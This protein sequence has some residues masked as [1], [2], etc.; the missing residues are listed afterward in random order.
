MKHTNKQPAIMWSIRAI[1]LLLTVLLGASSSFAQEGKAPSTGI[2][3]GNYIYNFGL[4]AGYRSSSLTDA[5]G[6]I[7]TFATARYNEAYNL[8]SGLI[9]NSFNLYGEKK[10]GEGFFDEMSMNASGINDPFTTGSFRMRAYNSYDFKVDYRSSKYYL[11]RNDSLLSG[12]HKFDFT[13]TSLNA[14]LDVNAS[15]NVKVNVQYNSTG[16]DGG[17]VL[18]HNAMLDGLSASGSSSGPFWISMPRN[19]ETRDFLAS[20]NWQV[21]QSSAVTIGGGLRSFTQTIDGSL[22]ADS[23]L[24]LTYTNLG[25]GV[26][27]NNGAQPLIN[28]FTG[29]Y[30]GYI[31][32]NAAKGATATV[33][34]TNPLWLTNATYNQTLDNSTPYFFFE[35]VTRPTENVDITANVKYETT[36][37]N[38]TISLDQ[39]GYAGG[40]TKQGTAYLPN[41]STYHYLL[42]SSAMNL[43][44]T[45][46]VGS[47]NV[48]GRLMDELSVTGRYEYTKTTED[49]S[50]T[51][52]YRVQ[53]YRKDLSLA[54]DTSTSQTTLTSYAIPQQEI[55]GFLSYAPITM[56]GLKAG[57]RYTSMSPVVSLTPGGTLDEEGSTY[58]S[59]KTTSMTPYVNFNLRPTS[60]VRIDGRYSHT[61]NT[62]TDANGT[63]VDMPVRIVPKSIDA[64]SLGIQ[65]DLMSH[66]NG[67]L[68]YT[69]RMG[70]STL[71]GVHDTSGSFGNEIRRN[72]TLTDRPY[73]NKMSSL[74]ASIG[75]TMSKQLSLYVSGEYKQ[76]I[77]DIPVTWGTIASGA[78]TLNTQ[79]VFGDSGTF[80]VTQNTIDRYLDVTLRA[81]PIEA[82]HID[83]G[84]SLTSSSGGVMADSAMR[85]LYNK[86]SISTTQNPKGV[87][88]DRTLFG[89]PY[90]SYNA[91]V[92][93]SY[94]VTPNV[95]IM[96]DYQ[97]VYYKE[98]QV[99]G[100]DYYALNN[101]KGSLIRGGLSLK[102]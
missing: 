66:L 60:D 46:L 38:P 86:D 35:G 3:A 9:L 13:R 44:S 51:Y 33:S 1:A 70:T 59:E 11:N 83:A 27:V 24:P 18:T 85:V 10:G 64:F 58:L 90:T 23:T 61:S 8:H 45:R 22:L 78:T 41:D 48:T 21:D 31:A 72:L 52:N 91:H 57:V 92:Q 32:P 89:G 39:S 14:S 7:D 26:Y 98:D 100:A 68:R 47:L 62:A 16:R 75:Y 79:A 99:S 101:F 56:L 71:L 74:S 97:L 19:D 94:D 4:T 55:E 88:Q 50:G 34:G 96:A 63:A 80:M 25:P 30:G 84:I 76:N 2:D 82:L 54:R 73:D 49:G 40:I 69:G 12:L 43:K 5:N 37:F 81:A 42:N 77:Y 20:L 36:N 65:G 87:Y 53:I 95:G 15:D 17:A 93:V 6:N 67:S 29:M 102:F 28:A